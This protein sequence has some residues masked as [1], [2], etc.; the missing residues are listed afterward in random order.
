MYNYKLLNILIKVTTT[1]KCNT[2]H[3]N[4]TLHITFNRLLI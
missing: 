4:N 3:N 1:V 2:E